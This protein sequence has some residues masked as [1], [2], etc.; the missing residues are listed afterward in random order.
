MVVRTRESQLAGPAGPGP[1]WVGPARPVHR[2]VDRHTETTPSGRSAEL[3]V[4]PI[5]GAGSAA[6]QGRA[7]PWVRRA[8]L[9]PADDPAATSTARSAAPILTAQ[10]VARTPTDRSAAP[11]PTA[12]SAGATP[13]AR[14]APRATPTQVWPES[15]AAG[16]RSGGLQARSQ[17]VPRSVT[18]GTADAPTPAEDSAWSGTMRGRDN[19]AFVERMC[20]RSLWGTA[21]PVESGP[22]GDGRGPQP[23]DDV[24][25]A[26]YRTT[27]ALRSSIRV[28]HDRARQT[29]ATRATT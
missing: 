10:L 3:E 22:R 19:P 17:T 15:L 5:A 29:S 8:D 11:T 26:T 27:G 6:E 28:R 4:A 14:R 12:R 2:T 7:G 23:A 18:I 1:A 13:A 9:Q 16:S 21:A 24:V 20:I 25:L